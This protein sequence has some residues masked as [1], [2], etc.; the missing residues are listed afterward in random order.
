MTEIKAGDGMTVPAGLAGYA[1]RAAVVLKVD[2]DQALIE[3]TEADGSRTATWEP[4]NRLLV[5][6]DQASTATAAQEKES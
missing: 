1:G 4:F 3:W 2:G 6:A 5:Q